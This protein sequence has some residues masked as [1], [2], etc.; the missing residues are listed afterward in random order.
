MHY[1]GLIWGNFLAEAW[2]GTPPPPPPLKKLQIEFT[3]EAV[4]RMSHREV[5]LGGWGSEGPKGLTQP[6]EKSF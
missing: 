2:L 3:K 4:Y 1:N 5:R 6:Q